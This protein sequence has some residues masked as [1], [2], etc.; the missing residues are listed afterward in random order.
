MDGREICFP[1]VGGGFGRAE[2]ENYWLTREGGGFV[3]SN[4]GGARWVHSAA[5]RLLSFTVGDGVGIVFSYEGDRLV[6]IRHTRGRQLDMEWV[7]D[8]IT[9]VQADDG[10]RVEFRYDGSG[11][12]TEAVGPLGVRRYG[13]NAEGL[14]DVVVD[15]DGVVEARNSYDEQGRVVSQVS[16]FGRVTRFGYLPGRVT[17]VSDEDGS[18]SNTWVADARGRLVGITDSDGNRSSMAYDNKL[19][20]CTK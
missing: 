13:W 17:V 8:R 18:R 15:A 16:P 19:I 1:R 12:L 2:F 14:I 9:A 5:G 11:C 6:Q 7:G 4:N 20:R 3:V 10:R